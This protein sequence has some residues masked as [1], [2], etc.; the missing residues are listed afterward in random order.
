MTR[1]SAAI[2]MG[3][4]RVRLRYATAPASPS[5]QN[6]S[7]FPTDNHL[8]TKSN[9]A[10]QSVTDV[11]ERSMRTRNYFIQFLSFFFQ[12]ARLLFLLRIACRNFLQAG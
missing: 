7:C 11:P 4:P 3:Q 10:I 8:E 6:G 12:L 2:L 1:G 5:H 9:H